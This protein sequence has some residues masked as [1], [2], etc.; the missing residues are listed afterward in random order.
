M[1][2][3]QSSGVVDPATATNGV[4]DEDVEDGD[5]D[6]SEPMEQDRESGIVNTCNNLL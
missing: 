1:L 3:F 5:R 4:R 6:I 2:C